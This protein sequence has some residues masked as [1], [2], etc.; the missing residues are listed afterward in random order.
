[1]EE[2]NENLAHTKKNI[3]LFVFQRIKKVVAQKY[4]VGFCQVDLNEREE[5]A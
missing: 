5:K 2:E 3:S 1:M 4:F